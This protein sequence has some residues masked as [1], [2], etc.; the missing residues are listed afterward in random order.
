MRTLVRVGAGA[1]NVTTGPD[2]RA[3]AVSIHPALISR[4]SD[5][6]RREQ[7]EWLIDVIIIRLGH[8]DRRCSDAALA[9]RCRRA[10]RHFQ[11]FADRLEAA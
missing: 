3:S 1:V 7:P 11:V 9:R 5:D 4:R 8:R 2:G 10:A 6:H